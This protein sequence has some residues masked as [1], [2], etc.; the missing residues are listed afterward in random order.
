MRETDKS[1]NNHLDAMKTGL[2]SLAKSGEI[3]PW[4]YWQVPSITS[5]P[6]QRVFYLIRISAENVGKREENF[7]AG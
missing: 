7:K 6:K 4:F 1:P 3:F 2:P 5:K